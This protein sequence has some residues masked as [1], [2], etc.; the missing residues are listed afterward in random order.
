MR[1]VNSK[2]MQKGARCMNVTKI[3]PA[4][5]LFKVET[6]D[7]YKDMQANSEDCDFSEYHR[8]ENKEVVDKFK[9]ESNDRLIA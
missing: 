4:I 9:N 8:S 3:H 1:E 2:F 5:M 6:K 7:A